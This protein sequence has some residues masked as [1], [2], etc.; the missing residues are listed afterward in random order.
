MQIEKLIM[1][2]GKIYFEILEEREK[3][4]VK[5][6]AIVRLEQLS[7]FPFQSVAEKMAKYPNAT[8]VFFPCEY[9]PSL[10]AMQC[11]ACACNI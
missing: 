7:P 11:D 5:N 1:C 4:G 10:H 2:T 9:S 6:T 8:V 3:R